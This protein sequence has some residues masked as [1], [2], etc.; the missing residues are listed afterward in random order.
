MYPH[1]YMSYTETQLSFRPEFTPR[2]VRNIIFATII[3]SLFAAL[4]EPSFFQLFGFSG[5]QEWLSLSWDNGISNYFV[6]QPVSYLFVLPQ[7]Y[8]GISFNLLITLAFQ[9]Y[10]VWTVG[11]V[12]YNRIGSKEFIYLYFGTG[13]LA[14]LAAS[15]IAPNYIFSGPTPV[16][17]ALFTI[18]ML[19]D[20]ESEIFLMM[21]FPV[22]V[23]WLTVAILGGI[24]LIHISTLEVVYL[25][26]YLLGP[27]AAY[28]IGTI[29]WGMESPFAAT[30]K[31]D[32]FLNNLGKKSRLKRKQTAESAKILK[33]KSGEPQLQN[34]DRFIDAML[35]KIS[36][37]GENSL[38][39][40]EK[41]RMEK[42]SKFKSSHQ[43][44]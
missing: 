14:G 40:S 32:R 6:W 41:R 16:I 33:F 7:G 22:K 5:P 35:T 21:T 11:T 24:F 38:T 12:I 31:I 18:W 42:I 43:Q 17:L 44:K 20:P 30:A 15:F 23:K 26:F 8:N 2:A 39:W 3:I 19:T 28:L 34:D 25:F 29:A 27:L 13:I 4:I 10:I 36:K 37:Y 9:M 1:V